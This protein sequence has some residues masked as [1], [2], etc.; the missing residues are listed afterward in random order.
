VISSGFQKGKWGG[1][2]SLFTFYWHEFLLKERVTFYFSAIQIISNNLGGGSR[3]SFTKWRL[4][5]SSKVSSD[6]FERNFITKKP[7]S[8]VCKMKNVM[9]H[10]RGRGSKINQKVSPIIFRAPI[11]TFL[12]KRS[13]K[14]TS[15]SYL[16]HVFFTNLQ[17]LHCIV[18]KFFSW[19]CNL[20]KQAT[21]RAKFEDPL[22]LLLF[23]FSEQ[24]LFK[25]WKFSK[26]SFW[27]K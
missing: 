15:L 13:S 7:M 6:I 17:T 19:K 16:N 27:S 5:R 8:F 14:N 4:W 18:K 26:Q 10:G 1:Q 3:H 21:Y 12:E 24:F 2:L 25:K 22:W 23:E 9:S 20:F 11:W